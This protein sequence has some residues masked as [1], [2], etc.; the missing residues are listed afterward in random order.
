MAHAH[1]NHH[2]HHHYNHH[3]HSAITTNSRNPT[4]CW[5]MHAV[6]SVNRA[7]HVCED[8]EAR[9]ADE[10]SALVVLMTR[11]VTFGVG[12]VLHSCT[13]TERNQNRRD[14]C[15]HLA[16]IPK[17][18]QDSP[19]LQLQDLTAHRVPLSFQPLAF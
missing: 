9:Y 14:T 15:D 10:L 4:P 13:S 18:T 6:Q 17:R 16:L 3:N 7:K 12:S 11:L 19:T 2:H 1:T 8:G 5:R